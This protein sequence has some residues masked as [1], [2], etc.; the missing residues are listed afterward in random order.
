MAKY[1]LISIII[2][3]T[4]IFSLSI[5]AVSIPIVNLIGKNFAILDF[6][7]K[8]KHHKFPLVRLGG[9][10]IILGFWIGYYVVSFFLRKFGFIISSNPATLVIISSALFFLIGISDDFYK[11][12]PFTKLFFQYLAASYLY[13]AGVNFNGLEFY[14]AKDLYY[15]LTLPGF[16]S[17]L[18]TVFLIVGLTNG[19]NWLDGLDGLASGISFIICV[20]LGIIFINT[21]QFNLALISCSLAGST[22]GFL[23]YNIYPA[24][25]LM[26]DCGSYLLGGTLSTLSIIGLRTTKYVSLIDDNTFEKLQYLP[27]YMIF[28]LFFIPIVDMIQV[29][30][31]R[32]KD[33]QSPFYPDRRHLHHKLLFKGLNERTSATILYSITQISTCLALFL[34]DV[35]G[36]IIL[37]CLSLIFLFYSIL[38]CFNIKS[39]IDP[40]YRKN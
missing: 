30:V 37:S 40:S 6:P 13:I 36:K 5:S 1:E 23:R 18:I 12:K 32:V 22:I 35:K 28:L 17:Y 38:Y 20:S 9:I 8:R 26:G 2:T 39:K 34:F 11:L 16:F 4:F 25:I 24:K 27:I 15:S 33:G 21:G 14:P 3:L 29:I 19:F 31:L 10:G 7:N